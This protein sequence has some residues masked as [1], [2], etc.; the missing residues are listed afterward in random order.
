MPLFEE[1]SV[2]AKDL[3][4]PYFDAVLTLTSSPPS[5][6]SASEETQPPLN[7]DA[8]TS[9][10]PEPFVAFYTEH[11]NPRKSHST[12]N[13]NE[14]STGG[15]TVLVAPVASTGLAESSDSATTHAEA[16]FWAAVKTLGLQ[17]V[18]PIRAGE[19]AEGGEVGEV[20]SFWPPLDSMGDD[21]ESW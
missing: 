20:T 6:D 11:L 3:L 18:Q 10:T 2:A 19:D 12:T 1:T 17:G 9:T 7:S 8:P 4:K 5:V 13:L 21:D 15:P 14:T 16:L